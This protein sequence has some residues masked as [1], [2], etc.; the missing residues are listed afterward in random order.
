MPIFAELEVQRGKVQSAKARLEEILYQVSRGEDLEQR[1]MV[2][3]VYAK[4]HMAGDPKKTRGWH[5]STG[6]ACLWLISSESLIPALSYLKLAEADYRTLEM[7]APLQ[8][9]LYLQAVIH[10]TS[11][12]R[13]VRDAISN[14]AS[15]SEI[16]F[17]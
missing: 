5:T 13:A 2:Y 11:G 3:A 6:N 4:A 1:A 7:Y 16:M 15:E 8:D 12:D 9:M 14:K 10:E 17:S